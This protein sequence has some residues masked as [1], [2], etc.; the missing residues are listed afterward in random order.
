[1]L[2]VPTIQKF[3]KFL[4]QT[5]NPFT[6]RM[7]ANV[8]IS[9]GETLAITSYEN[10]KLIV[11]T[12]WFFIMFLVSFLLLGTSLLSRNYYSNGSFDNLPDL[13]I[14]TIAIIVC[15]VIT[16]KIYPLSNWRHYLRGLKI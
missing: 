8:E 7:N 9:T 2:H 6:D 10:Q 3:Y 12:L 15:F 5:Q 1:M 13:V 4:F 14:I 11:S 16:V